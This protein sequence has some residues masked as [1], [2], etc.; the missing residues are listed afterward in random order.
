M[1]D[2]FAKREMLGSLS[3]QCMALLEP[4]LSVRQ[5]QDQELIHARG[6]KNIG[7]C[8]VLEGAVK[9]GNYGKDGRYF[10]SKVLKPYESFGEFT[11]FSKLPRTHT[12]EAYGES[13]VGQI[14]ASKLKKAIAE[15]PDIAIH[16]IQSL[17]TRLHIS[18]EA[19]DDIKR[20]PVLVQVAKVL[21]AINLEEDGIEKRK[22]NQ[23]EIANHLG[24]SRMIVSSSLKK[25]RELELIEKSYQ[26]TR[27]PDSRKL[28]KWIK[29]QQQ[30][31]NIL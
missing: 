15:K 30:I 31:K 9:V 11:V 23:E 1:M 10:L 5:Y 21:Y 16:L 27:I 3:T 18:L 19:L 4:L 22:I 6:E 14:S 2:K 28:A 17:S 29:D 25:L 24:V 13:K 7:L 8:V 26:R 12:S 20:L